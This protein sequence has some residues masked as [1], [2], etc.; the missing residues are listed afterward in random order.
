[1][2]SLIDLLMLWFVVSLPVALLIG[3]IA[4]FGRS[5]ASNPQIDAAVSDIPETKSSIARNLTLK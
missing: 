1:M 4:K 5:N 2:I 3:A